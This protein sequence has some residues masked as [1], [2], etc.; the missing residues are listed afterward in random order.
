[1]IKS[2]QQRL[3]FFLLLPVSLLL[4]SV[5]LVGFFFAR[6][7][8]L[9]EWREASI[10][11]LQRAAHDIDMRLETPVRWI[12][13]FHN[14]GGMNDGYAVQTGDFP[15]SVVEI[16]FGKIKTTINIGGE[17]HNNG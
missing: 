12:K 14:T 9:N 16:D 2:L 8:M 15:V 13:M 6:N 4:F 17:S 1:M 7:V 10:L 11:R 5:G 3:V